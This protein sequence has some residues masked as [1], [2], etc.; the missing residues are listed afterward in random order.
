MTPNVSKPSPIAGVLF[1][2]ILGALMAVTSLSTD[3][4]LPAMP[5]MAKELQGDAELTVTGFLI[6][7]AVA[8][9]IWGPISDQIGRRKPMFIGRC[10]LL[11]AHW[12]APCLQ[13]WNRLFFGGCFKPSGPAPHRCLLGQ[14]CEI[15]FLEHVP[16]K[17]YRH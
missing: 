8:Q 7:F 11:S 17:C 6:G 12:A 4:Y 10:Y 5:E 9:L 16:L 3:I 13:V 14:W 1:L 15:Y 2:S